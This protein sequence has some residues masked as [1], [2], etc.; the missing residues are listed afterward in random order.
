MLQL[1]PGAEVV[2][3][4]PL[5]HHDLFARKFDVST[6]ADVSYRVPPSWLL[7]VVAALLLA[8]ALP[9]VGVWAWAS[10][11]ERR[12]EDP[13]ETV[14]RLHV[15]VAVVY[16]V[17]PL[18]TVALA[19]MGGLLLVPDMV[20]SEVAPIATRWRPTGLATPILLLLG[21][22]VL[23]E[24]AAFL[25]QQPVDRRVRRTDE[26]A[27]ASAVRFAR[28]FGIG[29]LPV[30]AWFTFAGLTA[31]A[32]PA[33]D[34][35]GLVGFIVALNLLGPV[36]FRAG[37]P[38]YRLEEPLRRRLLEQCRAQGLRIRDVRGIRTRSYRVANAMI[39]GLVPSMRY[40]LIT[41]YLLD[42]L[43]DEELDA[44]VAHEVAHGLRHHV[45]LKTGSV[46]GII[47]VA[48]VALALAGSVNGAFGLLT[49][50]AVVGLFFLP[51]R[52][53]IALEERADDDAC[54]RVGV[55]P[56][57]RALEKLARL[58]MTKRRTGAFWNA[59]QQHPGVERRIGR[60]QDRDRTSAQRGA[61]AAASVRG[62][63]P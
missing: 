35:G 36:L 46:L 15:G 27:P 40:V 45:L 41:D 2:G 47:A 50:A 26:T 63:G 1:H 23:T 52:L 61:G 53:G 28:A 17:V 33:V 29:L 44:I 49:I 4:P 34:F 56:V 60:L 5:V 8:M 48:E 7:R 3:R 12:D 20:F 22:V 57:V 62:G 42:N 30:A 38:T 55:E 39:T 59:M 10:N 13:V 51:G 31:G 11:V 19:V 32:G 9:F 18:V 37:Q 21:V 16:P 58:N 25:G 14:H 6:G 43:D 24:V 54:D